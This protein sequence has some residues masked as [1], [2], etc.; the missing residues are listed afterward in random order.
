MKN[1][2]STRDA[3]AVTEHREDNNITVDYRI[4]GKFGREC[5]G[6]IY[7]FQVFGGEKFGK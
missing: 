7:S 5:L 1:I 6:R 2:L 4:V 3:R